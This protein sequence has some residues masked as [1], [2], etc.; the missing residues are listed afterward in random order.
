MLNIFKEIKHVKARIMQ[1][2]VTGKNG[3]NLAI[4][5]LWIHRPTSSSYLKESMIVLIT[6]VDRNMFSK[7]RHL[8]LR[9]KYKAMAII[10]TINSESNKSLWQGLFTEY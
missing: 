4:C 2:T 1:Y 8:C 9:C 3:N 7:L 10:I 6:F 5:K